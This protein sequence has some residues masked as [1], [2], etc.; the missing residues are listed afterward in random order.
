MQMIPTAIAGA[1]IGLLSACAIGGDSRVPNY[2]A[3]MADPRYSC[4]E[5]GQACWKT[6]HEGTFRVT[7]ID[8]NGDARAQ[9]PV[10]VVEVNGVPQLV[11]S[12]T[13]VS[14]N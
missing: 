7:V 12:D 2:D 8:S 6:T 9:F 4:T 3:Y 10:N 1:L 14:N 11:A 13:Q 5:S